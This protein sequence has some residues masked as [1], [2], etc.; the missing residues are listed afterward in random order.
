VRHHP[1]RGICLLGPICLLASALLPANEAAAHPIDEYVQ[2]TYIDPAPDRTTL[3]LNL[4]PGVLVAPEMVA[5]IDTDGDGEISE[6]EGEAYANEVLRDISLEVD[7]DP[8]PLT[9]ASSQFPTPLDMRAGLGTIRLQVAAEAPEGVPGDHSLSFRNDHQ[10]VNSKYLVNAF[11]KSGEVEIAKQDRDELQ[12][13]IRVDYTATPDA[14]VTPEA[15]NGPSEEVDQAAGSVSER[16]QWLVGYLYEPALSPWLLILGLGLSALLGGLHAL[17]PGHGKTLIAAYLIGSRGAVKH[18]AALGGIVTFTHTASVIGVGLLAL[19]AGQVIVPDILVPV[20]ETCAGLLV[21]ALGVRLVRERWRLRGGAHHHHH[22]HQHLPKDVK[23][24]DLLAMGVSGGLVP[25]PEAL[26]VMLVAIGLDRIALGLGLIVA[27]S[28]G[29]AAV[30]IAI[31]VLLV[32]FRGGLD[33]LDKP[34]STW[35]R[36]LPLVSAVIVTMLGAG[37]VL[38]GLMSYFS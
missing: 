4:T 3:E 31:G 18:A 13:G 23:P 15:D 29:L 24:S 16:A 20:L 38:K 8:Q 27:F 37:I 12:H 9:L 30:L 36:W 7:D 6:T 33:R 22:D 14:S 34:K 26:G 5:L 17:T 32:R 11:K 28:F 25:C 19:L 35:Q 10:P 21:V 1:P 2:N